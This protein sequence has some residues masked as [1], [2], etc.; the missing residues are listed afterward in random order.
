[1]IICLCS[2]IQ[3]QALKGSKCLFQEKEQLVAACINPINLLH[4][5]TDYHVIDEAIDF[6]QLDKNI[7]GSYFALKIVILNRKMVLLCTYKNVPSF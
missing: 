2:F 6:E 5:G 3:L 7:V 1:M 4:T